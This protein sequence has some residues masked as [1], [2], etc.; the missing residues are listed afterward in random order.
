V[1]RAIAQDPT[2]EW[3]ALRALSAVGTNR[4]EVELESIAS[5][6]HLAIEN[7]PHASLAERAD[8]T[9]V[10]QAREQLETLAARVR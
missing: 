7:L 6:T 8:A 4:P 1:D 9:R 5:S 2:V 3:Y 10:A